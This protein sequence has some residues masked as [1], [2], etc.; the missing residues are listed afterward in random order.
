MRVSYVGV[1]WFMPADWQP[2]CTLAA[3]ITMSVECPLIDGIRHPPRDHRAV[4]QDWQSGGSRVLRKRRRP[5]IIASSGFDCFPRGEVRYNT[6][7]CGSLV[8]LDWRINKPEFLAT[9]LAFFDIDQHR[10]RVRADPGF[11]SRRALGPPNSHG[12]EMLD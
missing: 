4:W 12:Q 7:T 8:R 5:R 9:V 6:Y 1:F 10:L 2:L 11:T 3:E